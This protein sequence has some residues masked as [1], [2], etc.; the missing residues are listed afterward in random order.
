MTAPRDGQIVL[1]DE[2]E[3]QTIS[4]PVCTGC[5]DKHRDEIMERASQHIFNDVVCCIR[6]ED[7][8]PTLQ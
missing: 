3:H 7:E 5:A 8:E 4:A 2:T 1:H 6:G